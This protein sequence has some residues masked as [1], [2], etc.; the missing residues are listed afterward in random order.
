MVMSGPKMARHM[1][2]AIGVLTLVALLGESSP[3]GA[4][5]ASKA[6][7]HT[8]MVRVAHLSP[9]TGSADVWV[10]SADHQL[11][12]FAHDVPYGQ[13]TPYSTVP[14]GTYA[15]S[16]F[17][18]GLKTGRPLLQGQFTV[19]AG[20]VYTV[21]VTGTPGHLVDRVIND[22]LRPPPSDQAKVRVIQ[23]STSV[24]SPSIRIVGGTLLASDISYGTVTDYTDVPSGKWNL[25]LS[26]NPKKHHAIDLVKGAVY[27]IEVLNSANGAVIRTTTDAAT[28]VPTTTYVVQSGDSFWS[29]AQSMLQSASNVPPSGPDVLAYEQRLIAANMSR[30][31]D[32]AN[33]SLIFVGQSLTIPSPR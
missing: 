7:R 30:L 9:A 16:M 26:T 15:V 14:A 18:T 22:E 20:G 1:G 19:A 8:A 11:V 3:A 24:G 21:A 32:P 31:T 10:S 33:P 6:V 2:L 27:S 17:P 25:S 13:V 23:A 5:V 28:P 29:I 4:H 12:E